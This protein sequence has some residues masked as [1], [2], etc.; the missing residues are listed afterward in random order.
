MDGA[1]ALTESEWPHGIEVQPQSD[2]VEHVS[3]AV[4]VRPLVELRH[5]EHGVADNMAAHQARL[6]VDSR[7]F[8]L[9]VYDPR[10]GKTIKKCLSLQGNPAPKDDWW[11]NPKTK[12]K[13]DFIDFCRS[14]GRFGKHFDQDGY[15]SETLERAKQDR[16]ENWNQLQELAGLI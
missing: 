6:A 3:V 13:V 10:K 1:P 11:T 14:E 7:A 15:P 9:L 8:P 12:E 16:L 5:P 4:E 2:E